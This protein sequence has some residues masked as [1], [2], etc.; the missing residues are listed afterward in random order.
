M[1]CKSGTALILVLTLTT[2]LMLSLT[3]FWKKSSLLLDLTTTRQQY[4]ENLYLTKTAINFAVKIVSQNFKLFLK[5]EKAVFLDFSFLSNSSNQNIDV[6]IN[7]SLII[8]KSSN[9]TLNAETLNVK[10]LSVNKKTN[11]EKIYLTAFL[12]EENKLLCRLACY[13]YFDKNLGNKGEEGGFVV[14]AFTIGNFI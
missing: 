3:I 1:C 11:D 12:Y 6:V 7:K 8:N 10:T 13:V 4:Y 2:F 14:D 9:K 5:E